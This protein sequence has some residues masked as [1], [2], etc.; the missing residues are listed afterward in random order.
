MRIAVIGH[1]LAAEE[2][3]LAFRGWKDAHV[4][5]ILP[6]TWKARSLG[7]VYRAPEDRGAAGAAGTAAP[8][9]PAL[10]PL[11]TFLT[12]RNSLF[13]WSG[14]GPLLRRLEP[15]VIYCWEEPWCLATRQVL[16]LARALKV[17]VVF[18]TAENRP[19]RLPWPFRALLRAAFRECPACVAPTEEIAGR[20]RAW[21]YAGKVFVIPLWIRPRRFLRA[22]AAERRLGYVGRLIPLKRVDLLV[23]ALALMEGYS[24]RIIG[25]GPERAR[26]EALAQGLGI[27]AQ[28]DFRGHID[29]GELERGL[30]GVSLL[31]MPTAENARQAEQFGKAAV[32]GVSCGLPVLASRT[33]NLAALAGVFPTLSALDLDSPERM[34]E[35]V[36]G[37]FRDFPAEASLAASRRRAEETYGPQA[38]ARRLQAAF[39]EVLS[40]QGDPAP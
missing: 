28:V 29:N 5:L 18:Y 38:A 6:R 19:K 35:A 1:P 30:E 2:N 32:E 40:L 11:P 39:A 37:V 4:D 16:R 24:L 20:V 31:V 15:D 10:H 13:M 26:L 33:G 9:E 27:R 22:G 14:L 3:R 25:D 23:R 36:A 12:G 7:H 34:A 17:P 8:G 21:G